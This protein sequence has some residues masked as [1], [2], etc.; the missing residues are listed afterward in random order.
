MKKENI[1]WRE[2]IEK[3]RQHRADGGKK[4]E[5]SQFPSRHVDVVRKRKKNVLSRAGEEEEETAALV[6]PGDSNPDPRPLVIHACLV[7]V[8]L[9]M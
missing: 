2:Y 9:N 5:A 6:P 4:R 8:S 3:Y 1:Q 7:L